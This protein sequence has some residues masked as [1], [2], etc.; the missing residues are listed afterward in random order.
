M[1]DAQDRLWNRRGEVRVSRTQEKEKNVSARSRLELVAAWSGIAFLVTY[2]VFFIGVADWFPPQAPSWTTDQVAALYGDHTFRIRL[3]QIGCMAAS[4][5]LFPLWVT[6]SSHLAR[7]ENARGGR[8]PLLAMVQLGNAILLQVFFVVA[9]VI[10]LVASFRPD[11]DPETLRMLHDAGW[12]VFVLVAPGYL[13]QMLCIAVASFIDKSDH[14]VIPRWAGYFHLWVGVS[15]CGGTL[16][17][18]FKDGPFAW[19]GLVGI[20]IPIALFAI[21]LVLITKLLHD[22]AVRDAALERVARETVDA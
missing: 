14:P 7:I 1:L 8:L 4:F 19:N 16:A 21:W 11:L 9:S 10:W 22:A 15:G 17:V 13:L 18:F 12:L 2:A 6:I 20:Y 3:G 5:L